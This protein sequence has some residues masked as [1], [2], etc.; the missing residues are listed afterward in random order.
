MRAFLAL[1]NTNTG[2]DQLRTTDGFAPPVFPV[3]AVRE[4][5]FEIW[6]GVVED[7]PVVAVPLSAIAVEVGRQWAVLPRAALVLR[8]VGIPQPVYVSLY[9]DAWWSFSTMGRSALEELGKELGLMAHDD[10]DSAGRPSPD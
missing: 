6:R 9:S 1:G 5:C 7:S 10:L 3:I 2:I 4:G 8:I